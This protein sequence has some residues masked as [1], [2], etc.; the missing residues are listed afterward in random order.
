[1]KC[2]SRQGTLYPKLLEI[3]ERILLEILI[4]KYLRKPMSL[5]LT[6]YRNAGIKTHSFFF[7][8]NFL[9]SVGRDMRK[10]P[11]KLHTKTLYNRN[12]RMYLQ[13]ETGD[14]PTVQYE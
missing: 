14:Q 13:N 12:S 2:R 5:F 7:F 11:V 8:F 6:L 4:H 9:Q 1:M 3:P 10:K